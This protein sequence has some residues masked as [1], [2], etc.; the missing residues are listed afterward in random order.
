MSDVKTALIILDGMGLSEDPVGNAVTPETMPFLFSQMDLHGHARLAASGEAVGLREDVVGNSEVGHLTIGAGRIVPSTLNRMDQAYT[1]GSWQ[2]HPLWSEIV[3]RQPC[4]IVGLL[5]DA[6]VHGHLDILWRSAE[7][8]VANGCTDV[9][10]H[11]VLDGVDSPAGSASELLQRLRQ[12]LSDLPHLRLGMVMGRKCFCDRSGSPEPA[13]QFVE[14]LSNIPNLPSFDESALAKIENER[15]FEPHG[16]PGVTGARAGETIV[17]T[18]HRADRAVQVARVM[19]ESFRVFA[20][21]AL[22]EAVP[23]EQAFFPSTPLQDGLAVELAAAG[24]ETTR[25]A[26]DCKFP[27][28]TSFFNGLNETITSHSFP[29]PT[30]AEDDLPNQPEMSA[31]RVADKVIDEIET[32][33]SHLLVVNIA[34]LD[35]IGHLGRLDL[36]KIAA[37]K[38]DAVAQRICEAA[39]RHSWNTLFVADHGNADRVETETGKAFGSHTA[40][41]VPFIVVPSPGHHVTWRVHEGSLANVASSVLASMMKPCPA[42]MH[43]PLLDFQPRQVEAP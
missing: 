12:K 24:L 10:V 4:H 8:A 19:S 5:S 26:E 16:N 2:R 7:L 17:L 38:V 43:P 40:R 39:A 36:A 23:A 3:S 15:D 33:S 1:D 32:G 31:D 35:Q 21:I 27:H 18:S 34:N 20:P 14:A 11:P 9:I 29:I 28:V 30:P 25:I 6:G 13:R 41:P 22:Q 37:A 42:S